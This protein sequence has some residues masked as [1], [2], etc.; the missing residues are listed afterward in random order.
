MVEDGIGI[1]FAESRDSFVFRKHGSEHC[2]QALAALSNRSKGHYLTVLIVVK[3]RHFGLASP[4]PEH[5]H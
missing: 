2:T 5:F 4:T 1:G 3:H